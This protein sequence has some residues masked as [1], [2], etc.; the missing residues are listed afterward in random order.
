MQ[1]NSKMMCRSFHFV[2][3]FSVLLLG[4]AKRSYAYT[5]E[6]PY[7]VPCDYTGTYNGMPWYTFPFTVSQVVKVE[8]YDDVIIQLGEIDLETAS[9]FSLE[10]YDIS[11]NRSINALLSSELNPSDPTE[12]LTQYGEEDCVA[13]RLRLNVVRPS[14][15]TNYCSVITTMLPEHPGII[16]PVVSVGNAGDRGLPTGTVGTPTVIDDESGVTGSGFGGSAL[17]AAGS[18]R[19]LIQ[20]S[21]ED[22][23][24]GCGV[25]RDVPNFGIAQFV[26]LLAL[27]FSLLHLLRRRVEKVPG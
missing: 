25:I 20:S 19:G 13:C 4:I 14:G 11:D 23:S 7:L 6:I 18:F 15:T 5:T 26:F 9:S 1:I 22:T 2:I 21:A 10:I 24:S 8:P 16:I 12:L 3:L 27:I 17:N